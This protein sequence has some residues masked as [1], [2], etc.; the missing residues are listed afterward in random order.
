MEY[1]GVSA[2]RIG[3]LDNAITAFRKA[4]FIK[5]DCHEAFTT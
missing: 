2:A 4:I 3:K 1:I 5:P